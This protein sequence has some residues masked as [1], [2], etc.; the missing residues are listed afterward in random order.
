MSEQIQ[1]LTAH[2]PAQIGYTVL[3]TS[4]YILWKIVVV[5]SKLYFM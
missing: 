2:Q 4:V 5:H 3:F 1:F